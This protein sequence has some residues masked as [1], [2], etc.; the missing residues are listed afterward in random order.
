[1]EFM[2]TDPA[3]HILGLRVNVWTCLIAFLIG[4][5]LVLRARARGARAEPPATPVMQTA[6]DPTH[7]A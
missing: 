1:M 2:R 3:N 7:P 6:A 5:A 4:L